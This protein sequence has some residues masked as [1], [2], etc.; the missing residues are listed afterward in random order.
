MQACLQEHPGPVA[1]HLITLPIQTRQLP[2]TS[3]HPWVPWMLNSRLT[4]SE[5]QRRLTLNLCLYCGT[6]G[7]A[8]GACPIRPPRPMV[9]AIIPSTKKMKPLTT[10]VNLTAADVSLTVVVLLDS[11]SAGNFISGALCRQL[12]LKTSPSP[13]VYQISSITGRPLSHTHVN[14]Y[15]KDSPLSTCLS[16]ACLLTSVCSVSCVCAQPISSDL[17]RLRRFLYLKIKGQ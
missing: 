15:L 2:R 16:P 8:I 17:Q 1:C 5:R 6:P 9:S 12:R 10:V 3:Q 14:A 13:T 11:G 7:H 4:P